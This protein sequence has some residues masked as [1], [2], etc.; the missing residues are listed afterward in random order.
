MEHDTRG[1]SLCVSV[2]GFKQQYGRLAKCSQLPSCLLVAIRRKQEAAQCFNKLRV[3]ACRARLADSQVH[4]FQH[5]LRR[6]SAI[7]AS[8]VEVGRG[9]AMGAADPEIRLSCKEL[10]ALG[11]KHEKGRRLRRRYPC[12]PCR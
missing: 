9:A 6:D 11:R 7:E 3:L 2:V 12:V 5:E 1:L 8:R 4:A 10:F